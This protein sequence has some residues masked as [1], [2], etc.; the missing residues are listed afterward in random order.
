MAAAAGCRS[1]EPVNDNASVPKRAKRPADYVERPQSETNVL[2]VDLPD[3]PRVRGEPTTRFVVAYN[4]M[5]EP[6][7]FLTPPLQETALRPGGSMHGYSV[8]D[9]RAVTLERGPKIEI[10][11]GQP[12]RFLRGD[13]FIAGFFGK[14]L[15][16]G[17]ALGVRSQRA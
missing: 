10:S 2:R 17:M 8:S 4:D 11:A 14:V 16:A 12:L 1:C 15:Y 7:Q 5:S 13:P 9:D 6:W 3:P